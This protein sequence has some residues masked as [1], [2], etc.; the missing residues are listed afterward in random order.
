VFKEFAMPI[1]TYRG[2][3][4]VGE[5][6]DRLYTRLTPRQ[7]V[8]VETALLKANPRLRDLDTVDEGTVLRVPDIPEI[9]AKASK[10]GGNVDAQVAERVARALKEYGERLGGRFEAD[11]EAVREQV[12][13][14][15]NRRLK[16][17]LGEAPLARELAAKA[18]ETLKERSSAAKDRH[19]ATQDALKQ[20]LRDLD[21][22]L[23]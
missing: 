15:K 8:K 17:A 22:M 6:A 12:A 20:A 3:D 16:A 1:A 10:G 5:I 19:Q 11:E 14:L 2:E 21:E 18:T 7:R 4:S 13:T 23:R 9:R